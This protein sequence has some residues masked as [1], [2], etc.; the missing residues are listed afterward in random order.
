MRFTARRTMGVQKSPYYSRKFPS[1][2]SKKKPTPKR[3]GLLPVLVLAAGGGGAVRTPLV[4]R[5]LH[6]FVSG[7]LWCLSN[8]LI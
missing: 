8:R 5:P 3:A 6:G 7:S 1:T 4:S 2:G